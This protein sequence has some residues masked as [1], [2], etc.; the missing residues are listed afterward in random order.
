MNKN[1]KARLRNYRKEKKKQGCFPPSV[2]KK[3]KKQP[4]PRPNNEENMGL[5]AQADM[6]R[7]RWEGG[8]KISQC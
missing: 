5:E 4:F 2:F 1:T 8:R 6:L 3:K 7:P